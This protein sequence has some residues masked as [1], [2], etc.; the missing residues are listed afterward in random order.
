MYQHWFSELA[1]NKAIQ[2]NYQSV[3]SSAGIRQL[4]ARQKA[5]L[6]PA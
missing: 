4:V 3:G 6:E 5:A 2:V 1:A